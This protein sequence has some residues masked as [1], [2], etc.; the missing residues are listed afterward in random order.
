MKVTISSRHWNGLGQPDPAKRQHW[1]WQVR[2][3]GVLIYSAKT[4]AS[5][6]RVKKEYTT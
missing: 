4:K 3:D 6:L 2:V 5:A 1:D